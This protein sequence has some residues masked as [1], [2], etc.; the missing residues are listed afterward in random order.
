MLNSIYAYPG[1]YKY[2]AL[3]VTAAHH[4]VSCLLLVLLITSCS[5]NE[6]V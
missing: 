5:I 1:E 4:K 6:H 3:L 2:S